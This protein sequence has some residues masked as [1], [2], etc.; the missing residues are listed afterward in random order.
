MSRSVFLHTSSAVFIAAQRTMCCIRVFGTDAFTPYMLM[1][2]PLYVAQPSASSERSPVPTTTPFRRF[3]MSMRIC[4]RSRACE[5]SYVTSCTLISCSMSLKCC[6]HASF[7]DISFIVVP[8][9]FI[10]FWALEYVRSVVPN[11]GIVTAMMSLCGL[12]SMSKA[13]AVTSSA[14]VESSPPEMPITALCE[15]VWAMRRASAVACIMKMS[16]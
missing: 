5:F 15:R 13:F 14:R 12:L 9:A 10:R 6:M 2:S 11:P 3:A 4:V 1:W 8:S 16:L 7:I